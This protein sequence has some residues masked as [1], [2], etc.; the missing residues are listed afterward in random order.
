MEIQYIFGNPRKAKRR[1]KALASKRKTVKNKSASKAMR[2]SMSKKRKISKKR[3]PEYFVIKSKGTVVGSKGLVKKGLLGRTPSRLTDSERSSI[4]AKFKQNKTVLEGLRKA[5]SA[6]KG[7]SSKRKELLTKINARAKENKK[8]LSAMKKHKKSNT[9]TVKT[10]KQALAAGKDVQRKVVD[11]TLEKFLGEK[12]TTVAKKKKAKKSKA[13]K[14]KKARKA[15]KTTAKK[16]KKSKGRKKAAKKA[17]RK[18]ARKAS[19]KA[20]RK[21]AKKSTRRKK[22]SKSSRRKTVA[23]AKGLSSGKVLYKV[24]TLEPKKRKK[25]SKKI[26]YRVKGQKRT[27]LATLKRLNPF[28]GTMKAQLKDLT[29]LDV[30]EAGYLVAGSVASDLVEKLSRKYL[31]AYVG[32]LDTMVPGG[33]KAVN[34]LVVGAAAALTH[35][36][37]KND[38]A[39]EV[40]KAVIVAQIV[41]LGS[42]L[43]EMVAK[44]LG[45]AGVD[46]TPLSGIPYG[47]RGVDYTPLSGAPQMAG[48][49]FIPSMG[50][51]PQMAGMGY[52]ADFGRGYDVS[53]YGG[54]GGYTEDR[55]FSKA[56]F[57]DHGEDDEPVLDQSSSLV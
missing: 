54:G 20:S 50:H 15:K 32:K 56:D 25:K 28:G 21:A 8:L 49:N 19:R 30:K 52:G 46:Y 29:G 43:T 35:K 42:S 11:S 6:A 31:G 4:K 22:K 53:D 38:H 44:P 3:N 7:D 36:Y 26:K 55:K 12:E 16:A 39:K 24:S 18:A 2:G 9:K 23:H 17:S 57:G 33:V 14:A 51:Q 37:A 1:K 41:K 10:L 27:V 34:A 45:L 47:L 40:A 5:F 48:V 13:K